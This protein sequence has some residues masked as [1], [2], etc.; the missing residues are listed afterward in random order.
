MKNRLALR[1]RSQPRAG[2]TLIEL[3]VVISIIAVLASL[4]LP[5]VQNAREA[6]RRMTCLN[7]MRNVGL[8]VLNWSTAHNGAIP[9]LVGEVD[10]Y[11]ST[12]G[13]STVSVPAPWT[14]HLLPYLDQAGLY[15]RITNSSTGAGTIY[16]LTYT[17][18]INI[19]VLTCPD[20]QTADDAGALS[21][22][23]NAGYISDTGW[24]STTSTAHRIQTQASGTATSYIWSLSTDGTTTTA[25][26]PAT[27]A[28]QTELA[29][30]TIATGVFWRQ[31][32]QGTRAAGV[33][34]NPT[35]QKMTIDKMRDGT[36]QTIMLSENI[37]NGGW[38]PAPQGTNGASGA[39]TSDVGFGI[40]VVDGGTFGS[41]TGNLDAGAAGTS[42]NL[43]NNSFVLLTTQQK[44]RIN[45]N[46]TAPTG[47]APRPASLHPQI[48]NVILCDGSGRTLNQA[49]N[50]GVYARLLSPNGNIYNQAIVD[51]NSY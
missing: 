8:S 5:G 20:D 1:P 23:A 25:P 28:G 13:T 15:D 48:V 14:V 32:S 44:S 50:D 39:A 34:F 12:N 47:T 3:L 16:D 7:N 41:P 26:D 40:A 19:K 18:P 27:L 30:R 10:Y 11:Y 36:S 17:N 37:S 46:L 9:P 35:S 29:K 24:N 31:D 33:S 4:I 2:F 43:G 42:T 51:G 21:F 38:L 49:I 6:A 45:T 22:A